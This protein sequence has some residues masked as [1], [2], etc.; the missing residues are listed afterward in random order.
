[1]TAPPLVQSEKSANPPRRHTPPVAV[2]SV[3]TIEPIAPLVAYSAAILLP[4]VAWIGTMFFALYVK[5]LVFIFFWPAVII[6]A[7]IGGFG[8]AFL[9]CFWSSVLAGHFIVP[10]LRG[11]SAGSPPELARFL[12]FF[13][14]ALSVSALIQK[15][16]RQRALAG[17]A[18]RENA[19][20]AKELEK[21]ANELETQLEESQSLQEEL[22]QSSEELVERTAEAET[23]ARFSHG[24][25][26]SIAD[27]F[28]VQDDKWRFS[29]IN[30]AAAEAFESGGAGDRQSLIGKIVWDVI[31]NLIGTVFEREM[32]R[33][34]EE[35]TPVTFEGFYADRGEWHIVSCYPL[36]DG[37]LATQ[38]NDITPLKRAEEA[39]HFLARATETLSS[40]L[41]YET[42]LAEIAKLAVPEIADWAAVDIVGDDGKPK[43]LSIAH[44][45][46]DKIRLAYE[47]NK[48]YPPDPNAPTGV[49]NVLRT[50]QPEF[51]PEI[52]EEMLT[53]GAVDEE[54]LKIIHELG[55]KSAIVAP[56]IAHGRTL[57][58]LTLVSAESGRRYTQADLDLAMELARRAALAVDNARLHKAALDARKAAESANLAKTQFL[59][60]MSHELRTPLNAI[61]GY[62][63]LMR[64]GIRGP[65]TPEQQADLDRI[66]RSQ[67]NLLSLIN[68]VLNYAKLEAGHVEFDTERVG[69]HSF[70][71]DIEALVR[72]QLHDKGLKYTYEKCEDH[73]SVIADAEK[74]RQIVLNLLSNAIKFT[75]SGGTISVECGVEES[76]VQICV[77]DTG[78]GIP[79]DKIGAIFD[80]FVQLDRKL[81]SATEGTGLGLSISRDLARGMGGDLTAESKIGEGS[82]FLL[83][84][85]R[86]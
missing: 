17:E 27:P 69:L 20:L 23:T 50:G 10:P 39:A 1:M 14:T 70:L 82:R 84:L 33:S 59:A 48:R 75:P 74:L 26:A 79:D 9:A 47:L 65:V 8:A 2:R 38:W 49:Y 41:D 24:I 4:L 64:M 45:N 28:V 61:A 71:D 34:A 37:G 56:M 12:A 40:S 51:Y 73:L 55:L 57:G 11:L 7:V 43:Q 25:L 86:G 66:K 46:P 85:P 21:Q 30:D 3:R 44:V 15:L 6:V 77:S 58:A 36:P 31:P 62:A 78:I 60:V 81:T 83:S 76:K 18:A 54:H 13:V 16:Q 32:R 29:Y 35:R 19:R 52:P 53:R 72:P 22:E 5:N 67:R 68:D 63:D 42:T 80:P